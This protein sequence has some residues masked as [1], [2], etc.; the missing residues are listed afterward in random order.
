[1]TDNTV[2]RGGLSLDIA[3][4]STGITIRTLGRLDAT[5]T[6]LLEEALTQLSIE[7]AQ[8]RIDLRGVTSIDGDGLEVL[9]R[10]A[11]RC[12]ANGGS[13]TLTSPTPAALALMHAHRSHED[14]EVDDP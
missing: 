7:P 11:E 4:D 8:L 13:L 14:F 5:T 10:L 3:G 1:M 2:P 9:L 6:D 12:R